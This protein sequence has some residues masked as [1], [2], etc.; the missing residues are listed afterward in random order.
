M[1]GELQGEAYAAYRVLKRHADIADVNVLLNELKQADQTNDQTKMDRLHRIL[2]LVETKNPGT[3][4]DRIEEDRRM[5]SVFWDILKP[6]I[7]EAV[8]Q[9]ATKASEVGKYESYVHSIRGNNG[10][11]SDEQMVAFMQIST[12]TLKVIRFVM[13]QHPDWKDEDVAAKVIDLRDEGFD[14]DQVTEETAVPV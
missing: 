6:D 11:L 5:R 10:L 14:P 1:I 8:A 12:D 4:A 2:G 3:I 7:D 13:L 9:A